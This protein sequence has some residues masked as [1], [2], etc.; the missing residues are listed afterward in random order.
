[1]ATGPNGI[2][3]NDIGPNS[4]LPYYHVQGRNLNSL[5]FLKGI[6]ILTSHN[7]KGM[8]NKGL[9]PFSSR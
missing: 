9:F 3:P 2:G 5:H 1:M 4:N 8:S 6:A 7:N